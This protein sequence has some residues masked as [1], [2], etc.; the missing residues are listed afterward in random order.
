VKGGSADISVVIRIIDSSDGTPKTA[1]R[2]R[3]AASI[4]STGAKAL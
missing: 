3:R 4:W 2:R 1:S